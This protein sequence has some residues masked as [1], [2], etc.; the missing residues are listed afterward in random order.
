MEIA[1][2]ID[3]SVGLYSVYLVNCLSVSRGCVLN[4]VAHFIYAEHKI[5]LCIG[6]LF[7]EV[8]YCFPVNICGVYLVCRETSLAEIICIFQCSVV[9]YA[10]CTGIAYEQGVVEV[11]RTARYEVYCGGGRFSRL[12]LSRS[13]SCAL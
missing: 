13:S 1:L 4:I 12:V 8:P 11:F 3:D 2:E 6:L 7:Q 9:A 5:Y 10:L